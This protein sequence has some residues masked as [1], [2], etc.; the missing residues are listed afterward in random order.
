MTGSD[1]HA[2]V[3]KPDDSAIQEMLGLIKVCSCLNQ[4]WQLG[5]FSCTPDLLEL[6]A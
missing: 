4:E 3:Y 2:G 6:H 5:S 1:A